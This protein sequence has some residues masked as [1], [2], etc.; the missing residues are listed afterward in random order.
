MNEIVNAG[1]TSLIKASVLINEIIIM[2][3]TAKTVK[4]KCLVKKK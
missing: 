4:I 3:N 2:I 1:T